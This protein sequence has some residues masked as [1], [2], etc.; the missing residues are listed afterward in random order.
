MKLSQMWKQQMHDVLVNMY[1]DKIHA[2][3]LDKELDNILLQASP[4]FPNLIMRNLYSGQTISLPLDDLIDTIHSEDLCIEAN[5]TLTYSYKK[6]ESPIPSILIKSK[7]DR[8]L[9]KNKAKKLDSDISKAKENG[10]YVEGGDLQIQYLLEEAMQLKV[11]SFMNSIYGVQGQRGSIIYSPD[12]AAA[13]TAQG[14]QLISE[15]LWSMERL[16]YGTLHFSNMDEY[17]MYLLTISR[18][19]NKN[20]E[21]W[22]Y[23]T[24]YPTRAEVKS[25]IAKQLQKVEGS[26]TDLDGMMATLF[27]YINNLDNKDLCYLYYKNNIMNLISKNERVFA[28]IDSILNSSIPFMATGKDTPK[29]YRPTLD[30]ICNIL[31]EFVITKLSTPNRVFKYQNKRRRGIIVSDTD[32]VIINL[33]PLVASIYKLH[34]LENNIPCISTNVS[35]FDKD[36]DFKIANTVSYMCVHATVVAGDVLCEQGNVPKELRSW[37]EMKNEFLFRRLVLYTGAKKNYVCHTC[38]RE[39]NYMNKV[40]TTG[41]KLNSS[42]INPAI[43]DKMMDII[44][45][46]ILKTENIDPA[47][48]L[49]KVKSIEAYIIKQVKSG[50]FTFGRKQRFSG[51]NGYKTGI[52]QN[53]SGRSCLIWNLLNPLSKINAGDYC[54]ILTTILYSEAEVENIRKYDPEMCDKIKQLIFH[55]KD[56]PELAKYGL[57][58]IAFPLHSNAVTKM[59]E[60]IIPFIDYESLTN[61]HLQPIITLLPSIGIKTSRLSGTKT[62]YSPLISF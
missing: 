50:D 57:R 14:R 35:F 27:L 42:T 54:Y 7:A 5:N 43:K 31:D 59:P 19:A 22:S 40:S 33:H 15:M 58:S 46:D 8:N 39:G 34:C 55:N 23:I 53:N 9:H 12:T 41:I 4:R 28:L 48:I 20:S 26:A 13:V 29:E 21:L 37:I 51:L 30:L 60:W 1:G 62:T 16:L 52:Y 45:N 11:K 18:Q 25:I 32:S 38:L 36:M 44:E 24:Y 61:K 10:T 6:I 56:T 49:C 47:N 3:A 17:M 2:D